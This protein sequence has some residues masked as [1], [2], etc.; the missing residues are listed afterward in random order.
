MGSL[1]D[2]D[3]MPE[4]ATLEVLRSNDRQKAREWIF[5]GVCILTLIGRANSY[6]QESHHDN[7][8]IPNRKMTSRARSLCI[9]L[10]TLEMS[11]RLNSRSVL[12]PLLFAVSFL[13]GHGVVATPSSVTASEKRPNILFIFS[14]DHAPNAIGAFGSKINKTPNLD[15]I[16]QEGAKFR[17]SFCANSICGPSR[18]CILTGKHSHKNGFLIN[19]N[20]FDETQTTFPKLMQQVGYQTAIVGKWHLASNPTGFDHWEVLPGQG[21]YYNPDLI[22]MDKSSK[23][24]EG[25]CTDV[26][27]HLSLN[28]LKEQR[29]PE[30]S[31][32]MPFLIRWPGVIKSGTDASAMIQNIDYG[33]TFLEVAEAPIPL[34][35]QGVQ[36]CLASQ[37]QWTTNRWLAR[38][39]LL[40]IL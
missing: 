15:R 16:A 33:P 36:P 31:L 9:F 20:R 29:H 10:S 13:F 28:W 26:I 27:T 3:Q 39:N 25:Y 6:Q 40:R 7:R 19:G 18:A 14:D 11:M 12:F 32:R 2:N 23:R 30:P 5:P 34:E 37:E 8:L 21:S 35:M 1:Y 38:C 22:Q 17:N 24:Y 4:F